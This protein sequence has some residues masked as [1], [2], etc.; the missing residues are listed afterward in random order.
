MERRANVIGAGLAGCEAAWQLARQG[1]QVTLYEMKPERK[2][3]AHSSNDF[4]ELVCSNSLRSDQIENAVGL[5]KEELRILGSVVIETAWEHRLPAGGAMAVDREGF[6]HG[7]TQKILHHPNIT[8]VHRHVEQV[9]LEGYTV[10]ATGPLSSPEIAESITR[11]VGGEGLYFY[12]AAAPI[13]TLDSIDLSQAYF[14][15]RYNKGTADYINCP[16]S[17]EQYEAFYDALIHAE[18]APTHDFEKMKVFEGCMPVEVMAKRGRD[19]LLYGPMKPVGLPDPRT[20]KDPYAVVQLR[21]D[22]AA[23]TLYNIVGFQTHLK[24]PEQ[25][26]VFGMIPG[27]EHAHIVR[28]GVMHRNTF[29]HSPGLLTHTF[30]MKAHPNLYFAGQM[31]GVEGYV[32]S[33]ASGLYAGLNLGR[34]L[35]GLP[36]VDFTNLTA[37]GALGHYISDESIKDFQPMNINYGIMA[38]IRGKYRHKKDKYY[39]I[40]MR[41]L[42]YIEMMADLLWGHI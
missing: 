36:E 13:V 29:L 20:G 34:K 1:V 22:N 40:S 26:R 16:M 10:V 6:A 33:V 37:I 28:Y 39:D 17:Q 31:T 35:H 3:P 4:C 9:P 23:G 18:E 24:F 2:T 30:C 25:K 11:L 42:D 8:V 12:D 32:E 14:A 27:L 15:S 41:A 38:P 5:L 19:T 7:V 21:R